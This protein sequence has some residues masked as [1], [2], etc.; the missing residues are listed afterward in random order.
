MAVEALFVLLQKPRHFH[1]CERHLKVEPK[2]GR[3]LVNGSQ[4]DQMV[5]LQSDWMKTVVGHGESNANRRLFDDGVDGEVPHE[6]WKNPHLPN[7]K[8]LVKMLAVGNGFRDLIDL[9][10]LVQGP[11]M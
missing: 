1:V 7:A 4:K 6:L 3:S 9:V 10:K 11:K 8:R 5:H 2:V